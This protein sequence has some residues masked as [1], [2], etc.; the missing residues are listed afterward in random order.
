MEPERPV[1]RPPPA[2][3]YVAEQLATLWAAVRALLRA[4]V[5]TA[6]DA[7]AP[8]AGA[9]RAGGVR[10]L[11]VDRD[12]RPR[13]P[14]LPRPAA[15]APAAPA[16]PAP[17]GSPPASPRHGALAGLAGGL[18]RLVLPGAEAA[19]AA[20]GAVALA[21][22]ELTAERVGDPFRRGLVRTQ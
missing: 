16:A 11:I 13:S 21:H 2:R 5:G 14:A 3:G 9:G 7:A 18:E 10:T 4:A 19:A 17:A 12:G 1:S 22:E 8:G 15:P 20:K 6:D